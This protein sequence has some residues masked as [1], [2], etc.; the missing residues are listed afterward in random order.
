[1]NFRENRRH[2]RKLIILTLRF[3]VWAT[4]CSQ[5][6]LAQP[7][8]E[9][10]ASSPGELA[11]LALPAAGR[12][13]EVRASFQLLSISQ[14]RDEVEEVAFSGVLTL[15]WHDARQAFDP[16]QEGTDERV[17][18]GAYQ[19]NELS[20]GWYP[21]VTL[22]NTSGHYESKAVLLRVKPDGTSTL[23]EKLEAV[24]K[25]DLDERRLPFDRQQLVLAFRVFGFDAS[26]VVFH[27]DPHA[28]SADE[29]MTR[30]PQWTVEGVS[31]SIRKLN[32]VKAAHTDIASAFVVTIDVKRKPMFMLRLVVLPMGLIV[33]L[34]WSVFWMDRSS[35]GDRMSVSFVG[36]L[37]AVAYQIT[38]VG[39]VPNV[40][41]FTLM[42][43]FLSLSFLLMCA[44]VVI[45]LWVAYADSQGSD[46]GDRI[47]RCCRWIF[48]L[49]YIGLNALA[50]LVMF[51]FV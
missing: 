46:V 44:T 51:Y 11:L 31:A 13:I 3:A 32:I 24:A 14:I 20:P 23:S 6:A 35:V 15:V 2:F 48:P 30:L 37:S 9:S 43:E 10:P 28:T 38:L 1:M 36:I 34:S 4:C 33:V 22:V 12:P 47:D 49:V 29:L 50:V 26:E 45:N 18:S 17:F 25:V 40:S 41:Y 19:F 42:N 16:A 7:N 5:V 27:A 39:I 21:Q 8:A